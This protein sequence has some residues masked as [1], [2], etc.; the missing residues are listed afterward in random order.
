MEL[1]AFLG[2]GVGRSPTG[3]WCRTRP[4]CECRASCLA[5]CMT[6]LDYSRPRI[7]CCC[8]AQSLYR[9]VMFLIAYST[10]C[11]QRD[12]RL[13]KHVLNRFSGQVADLTLPK[14]TKA[15]DLGPPGYVCIG[16]VHTTF[17][18]C[19]TSWERATGSC[20]KPSLHWRCVFDTA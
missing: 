3:L 1:S 19:V 15:A 6:C 11:F 9:C 5:L 17:L 12:A 8:G 7:T 13:E 16:H 4:C 2:A 14:K 20:R 18:S 10:P